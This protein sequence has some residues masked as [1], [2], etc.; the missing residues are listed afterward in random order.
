MVWSD[1]VAVGYSDKPLFHG[2][3]EHF[4]DMLAASATVIRSNEDLSEAIPNTFTLSAQPDV[5]RRLVWAFDSHA[6]ITAYT[7]VFTGIDAKGNTISETI[8]EASGWS[9]TTNNAF[10]I[11]TSI[12]MTSRTGTGAADTMDIGTSDVVGLSNDIKTAS[13]VYKVKKNNADY[14]SV[15][16]TA[17]AVYDTV[18]LS[19]GGA[20]TGGDDFTIWYKTP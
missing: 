12:I 2:H 4:Q 1:V 10:A 17:E 9:G 15:S 7:I 14:A 8:T 3:V 5:P 20:I 19:T 6:Q 18:D 16:Y 13:W 11:I